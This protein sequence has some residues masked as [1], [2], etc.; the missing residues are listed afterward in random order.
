MIFLFL[1]QKYVIFLGYGVILQ[2]LWNEFSIW[3]KLKYYLHNF[4]VTYLYPNT[5]FRYFVNKIMKL[6]TNYNIAKAKKLKTA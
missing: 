5:I 1:I 4:F 6:M 3:Q 2:D